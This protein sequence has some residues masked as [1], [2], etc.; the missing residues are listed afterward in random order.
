MPQ[1]AGLGNHVENKDEIVCN[2][3]DL[4]SNGTI[5]KAMSRGYEQ[6]VYLSTHLHDEGPFEFFIP[7][8]SDYILLPHTRLH[9]QG[10][11]Q[12]G[13]GA[14]PANDAVYSVCNLFPH[15]LFKQVDV[16]IGGCNTSSQDGLYPY[17]AFFETF[18]SYSETS[19]NSHLTSCS[20]WYPDTVNTQD[21]L[22]DTNEGY[23]NRRLLVAP[24]TTF[25]FCIPIHADV[26]Q[27]PRLIPPQT[28]IKIVL[29]RMNDNFSLMAAAGANLKI[30]LSAI[31]LFIKKIIPTEAVGL[32]YKNH[33]EKKEVILPFSRSIIKRESV[34]AGTTNVF[35]PLF[36]G[37]LPRQIL[38]TFVNSLRLDGRKNLNP[39]HFHHANVNFVNLR[40]NGMSEPGRPYTPDFE[41]GL[42]SREIRAL[43]D[44]TG[45]LTSD[46]GFEVTKG[47]FLNGKTFFAW[48]LTPDRCN[49]FHIHEKKI[50]KSVDIDIK[51]SAALD[52]AINVLIYATYET[53]IKLLNG[54]TIEA[55][56]IN[57]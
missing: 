8:S 53:H 45:V 20:G 6:E 30:H 26:L 5:E 57:G 49:G 22:D 27:S 50:G 40:I 31:S 9:I 36:N 51:F 55:N 10:K 1:S 23:E 18:F 28:P 44:N 11:I 14:D 54:Q 41:N 47:E 48:D 32:L 2:S 35:I 7:A 29:S 37:Q 17:K 12:T 16:H 19:K 21:A 13:A 43:Y 15:A 4:F 24:G 56:F 25:D 39:F 52:A 46:T 33:L 3:F 38:L 42:V 34:A